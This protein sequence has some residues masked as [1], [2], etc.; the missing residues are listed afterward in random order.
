MR[1]GLTLDVFQCML[2]ELDK[3]EEARLFDH[4]QP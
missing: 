2:P 1:E 3:A 4:E